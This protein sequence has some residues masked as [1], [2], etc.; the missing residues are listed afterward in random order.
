MDIPVPAIGRTEVLPFLVVPPLF[1]PFIFRLHFLVFWGDV[2]NRVR[3]EKVEKKK[4]STGEEEHERN[5]RNKKKSRTKVLVKPLKIPV[6]M[7][8]VVQMNELQEF[9]YQSRKIR[10]FNNGWFV[11]TDVCAVLGIVNVSDALRKLDDDE[12]M[13]LGLTDSHSGSRG[14]A[15]SINVINEPGLYSLI[16]SSRKPEAKKFKR[17]VTHEV[18]PSIRKTGL[19]AVDEVLNNPDMLI[20]AL[21]KLKKEREERRKLE[22]ENAIKTQQ[23]AEMT[24]K[25]SYY[26]IV[27]QSPSLVKTGVIASDFGMSANKLNS[28]LHDLGVQYKQHDIWL[29]YAEYRDKGYTQTKTTTYGEN[30]TK[31]WTYWTQKGRLFIYDLLKSEGILPVCER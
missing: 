10:V 12:K 13:T 15:Q 21:M 27:L 9:E 6:F 2:W 4:S 24:P 30:K 20:N 7:K 18:L 16:M 23:I 17:W 25:V 26:D 22:V 14:G 11:A 3:R 29:L 28:L 31:C 19:Y 1:A 5:K 8:E